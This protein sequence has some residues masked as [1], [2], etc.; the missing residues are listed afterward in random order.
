ML[1]TLI[2]ATAVGATFI[3]VFCAVVAIGGL[4]YIDRADS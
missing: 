1:E 2:V 3:A 4:A